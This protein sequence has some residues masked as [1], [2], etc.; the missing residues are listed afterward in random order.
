MCA[1]SAARSHFQK[2]AAVYQDLLPV[3]IIEF[4]DTLFI[5]N[6]AYYTFYYVWPLDHHFTGLLVT[7]SSKS[8][9]WRNGKT[10]LD[11]INRY[12][13]WRIQQVA[14]PDRKHVA[15]EAK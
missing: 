13:Q 15:Q 8:P 6:I 2:G 12:E 5:D 3:A 10:I 7:R 1:Y 9:S 4:N 11:L 14:E